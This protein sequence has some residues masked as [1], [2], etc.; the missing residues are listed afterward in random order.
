MNIVSMFLNAVTRLVF[1]YWSSMDM[2][3]T[4]DEVY[5]HNHSSHRQA[6]LSEMSLA[7]SMM[8]EARRWTIIIEKEVEIE[9]I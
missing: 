6:L 2:Q 9:N 4:T 5:S 1:K 8:G 7:R 3:I